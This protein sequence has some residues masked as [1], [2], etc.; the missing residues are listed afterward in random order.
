[1]WNRNNVDPLDR[2]DKNPAVLTCYYFYITSIVGNLERRDK[3]KH[4]YIEGGRVSGREKLKDSLPWN[5]PKEE[6]ITI[7]VIIEKNEVIVI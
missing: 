1:L 6:T 5:F 7:H 2:N 3:T 4:I